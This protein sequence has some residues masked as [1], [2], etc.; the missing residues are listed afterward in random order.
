MSAP[1][2]NAKTA[3]TVKN[4]PVD[5]ATALEYLATAIR[6]CTLAGLAVTVGNIPGDDTQPHKGVIVLPGVETET[7]AGRA[8]FTVRPAAKPAE[9]AAA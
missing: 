9:Q 4:S 2:K 6:E 1:L 3:S 8:V 5:A 7:R